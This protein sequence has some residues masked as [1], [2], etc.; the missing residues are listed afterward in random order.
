M[1]TEIQLAADQIDPVD[2][3]TGEF[4][5][6]NVLMRM[7]G[8]MMPFEL[9]IK[10]RS[11]ATYDGPLGWNWAHSYDQKLK[12]NSDGSV[13]YVDGGMRNFVFPIENNTYKYLKGLEATLSRRPDSG[14]EMKFRDGSEKDFRP[15]GMVEKIADADG[16]ALTFQYDTQ[17][18]LSGVTDALGRK[19]TY[20]Y[21]TNGRISKVADP[22]GRAVEFEYFDGTTDS[23]SVND[24]KSITVDNGPDAKKTV[25]FTYT[26]ELGSDVQSHNLLTLMD[27]KGQEYVKN[28]YAVTDRVVSQKFGDGSGG[29]D[30]QVGLIREDDTPEAVGTGAIVGTYVTKNFARNKRGVTTEYDFDR[31]GNVLSRK[32]YDLVG[33]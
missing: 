18:R 32:T 23:G 24:L 11:Q 25:K 21:S 30:Y 9:S 16:N 27:A 1:A 28:S 2:L 26:K 15:D 14:F 10:Y 20:S 13:T 6:D 8:V 31:M 5:Y 22:L 19:A 33:T 7:P 4:T 12:E 17:G 29:F 3:S